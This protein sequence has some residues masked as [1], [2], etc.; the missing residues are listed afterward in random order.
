MSS[1]LG[2]GIARSNTVVDKSAYSKDRFRFADRREAGEALGQALQQFAGRDDVVVL[3]LPRGGV[4]VGYAV[5]RAL[6]AD[7]DVFVVRKLG[8][9][10]HPELAMGAIASGDVRVLNEDVLAWHP[11]SSEA[12]DAVTRRERVELQRRETAY[13]DGRTLG[14][15]EGR[16]VILVDDGLATGST[17][18]A[19]VLAVRRLHPTRVV[20]AV[21]VGAWQTC[22]M[23]RQIADEVICP[24]TPEPFTAV[25]LW[26][27]D[28]SQTTDEEVRRLVAALAANTTGQ[29]SRRSA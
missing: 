1:R 9:P 19:A 18:R 28:F 8:L 4:P 27:A 14:P 29:A 21:P 12:I 3:A 10:G 25:G 20:V 22:Q 17:M 6:R 26:Y 16:T 15:I 7:L 13:R 2:T 23:L 5:A 24:F 11:T